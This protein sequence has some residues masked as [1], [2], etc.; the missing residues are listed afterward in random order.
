[1]LSSSL[2]DALFWPVLHVAPAE[3]HPLPF[4]TRPALKVHLMIKPRSTGCKGKGEEAPKSK[5]ASSKGWKQELRSHLWLP[6]HNTLPS[7]HPPSTSSFSS[8]YLQ[9]KKLGNWG[10]EEKYLLVIQPISWW[11][12]QQAEAKSPKHG[13]F[14]LSAVSKLMTLQRAGRESWKL[15][16]FRNCENHLEL[17]GLFLVWKEAMEISRFWAPELQERYHKK[18]SSSSPQLVPAGRPS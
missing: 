3:L 9:V 16:H 12:R 8:S 7:V 15:Q 6:H 11:Y 14:L 13:I 4:P 5:A 2:L 10:T 18:L 1:V 17:S